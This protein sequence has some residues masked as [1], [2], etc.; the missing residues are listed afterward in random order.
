MP[1]FLLAGAVGCVVGAVYDVGWV[2]EGEVVLSTAVLGLLFGVGLAKRPIRPLP[3]WGLI[4]LYNLLFTTVYLARLRPPWAVLTSGWAAVRPYW[5]GQMALFLDRLVSWGVAA[6]RGERSEETLFFACGLAFATWLLAAYAGWSTFREKRPLLGLTLLGMAL[7][8]NGYFGLA[9]V[10]WAAVFVALAGPLAGLMHFTHLSQ[11]WEAAKVDYSSEIWLDLLAYAGG[12][13][14]ITL[15]SAMIL[16]AFSLTA[17]ARAFQE[18]PLV[19]QAEQTLKQ[20]FAGVDQPR[21]GEDGNPGGPGG[22]GLL[23]RAYLLGNAPELSEIVVMTATFSS[24]AGIEQMPGLHWRGFSYDVYTGRGW[25]RS[26]ERVE[27]MA[28][29]QPIP[30]SPVAG[31]LLVSQSVHWIIDKRPLRYT[32]GLPV[33]FDQEVVTFWRGLEDLVRVQGGEGVYRAVSQLSLVTPDELRQTAVS[34]TP[35][36]ILSRY[37]AL[38][39]IPPAIHEL[40]QQVAGSQN[41]PYDQSKNLEQFLRQYPYSLEVDLPPPGVDPVSFF[42]FELQ[43]GYCDY[44]ASAMVVMARSLGLPARLVVGYLAQPPDEQ[45]VQTVY[46]IHSHAWVEVYFAGYGWVEF[47]PTAAFPTFTPAQ[48]ASLAPV[49]S[50]TPLP[51]PEPTTRHT[52]WWGWGGVLLMGGLIVGWLWQRNRSVVKNVSWAYGRLQ[53][54]ARALG[55]P[56]PPSQTPDEFAA[57]FTSRLWKYGRQPRLASLVQPLQPA[58]HQLKEWFIRSRYARGADTPISQTWW[59]TLERPLWWLRLFRFLRRITKR[60]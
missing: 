23:P 26:E 51:L 10:W 16:P 19:Q 12:I 58:I 56:T 7:A 27:T 9:P 53:H 3:A 55:Q 4:F 22:S 37:T 40:A 39:E 32:V 24:P 30:H 46:Q 17:W 43:R 6:W 8:I 31:Q 50:V 15:M 13:G 21:G 1:F 52:F 45:G 29:N 18:Q 35:A 5:L 48:T 25:A 59:V 44:Y 20:V 38:P 2:P 28:A 34:D 14:L 41:N 60:D 42:L 57:A 11:Q 54:Q 36:V 49:V 47:E 33:Q